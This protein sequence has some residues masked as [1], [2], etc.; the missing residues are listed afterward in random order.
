[1]RVS[2]FGRQEVRPEGFWVAVG[3]VV[4]LLVGFGVYSMQSGHASG[5]PRGLEAGLLALVWGRAAC[6]AVR[7]GRRAFPLWRAVLLLGCALFLGSDLGMSLG[8]A[9]WVKDVGSLLMLSL[10]W[11][12]VEFGKRR[13]MPPSEAPP[14]KPAA[15]EGAGG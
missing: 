12:W 3:A 15:G 7:Q 9:S 14:D 2:E 11:P 6:D 13:P 4:L 5:V 1:M 8:R 10:L